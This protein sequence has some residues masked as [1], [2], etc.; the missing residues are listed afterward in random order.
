MIKGVDISN[1]NGKVN[2]NLLKNEDHQFV[3]SKATEGA[4]FIDRFYN[5][6]IAN[7]KALGLIAGGYHFANFQDRAKAIREANFFKSIAAGAK[8]DF[9][10]LDFEQKCSR[11]MT[12]A[13]LAFLDIISDIAPALIYCNPSYIKEH[14]NSK[15]TKYPLWVAHYGVKSPSFTL[16]D[17]YSIWQFIDKGQISGVIGYI[18]LNYM[19]EDFYNSL[20]GGKKKVKNIVVYNYGPDQNS[21]EILAD[22]L[23]CPTISNGRKF[24]FSQ[25]EN[26]YAV[27][28]NEK[29]YTS[30]LTKLISG[31]DRYATMQLV[32]N[33][34]KN[35]GK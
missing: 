29:Q 27:G 3:I 20:K 19:T 5:N 23:N 18:D 8:P 16:W 35:W 22:Y 17:K 11:D 1:L 24:D 28:G 32:L 7:T 21:A 26:V 34:I 33:F 15:I 10:V 12:D 13:C 4:T 6:N 25:V 14:L 9:V 31:S 2:I 30:Y